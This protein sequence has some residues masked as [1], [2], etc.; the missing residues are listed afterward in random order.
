MTVRVIWLTRCKGE[1]RVA[2][3]NGRRQVR[4]AK[5]LLLLLLL[6]FSWTRRV[7]GS[8]VAHGR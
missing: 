3:P 2:I 7:D 6:L 8:E 5:I 4:L 1:L